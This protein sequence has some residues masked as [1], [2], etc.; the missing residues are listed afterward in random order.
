[1]EQKLSYRVIN[2]AVGI[3]VISFAGYVIAYLLRQDF[4]YD[5]LRLPFATDIGS[6]F[7][8]IA[9]SDVVWIAALK[10][11]GNTVIL[12]ALGIVIASVIGLFVGIA[13]LSKNPLL[14][15]MGRIYVEIVRNVPL[16]VLMFLFAFVVFAGLP[17]IG[18]QAGIPGILYFSNRGIAVPELVVNNGLW[19]LWVI[20]LIA[21]AVGAVF[22]RR[23]LYRREMATG[24]RTYG[25]VVAGLAWL[26]VAVLS[27]ILLGGPLV[28]VGPIVD[29]SGLFPFY[30]RG[31]VTSLG[32]ISAL[33]AISVYFGAF[34]AEIVR[35]SVQAIPKQQSEAAASLG[36]SSAQSLVLVI[37]PQA[38]RIMSPALNNEYQNANKDSSLSHLITYSEI[39]FIAIQIANNRGHFIELFLGVFMV[40]VL[41]NV[42]ISLAMNLLNKMVQ[43]VS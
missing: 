7:F 1:M 30:S 28:L 26:L 17:G 12:V 32:Y 37:L 8:K 36:L 14:S 20:V 41:L 22:L 42:L 24:T 9:S 25:R 16:L 3:A 29:Q 35:G 13:R 27:H 11:V 19:I 33:L 23:F 18:E 21:A 39:V 40:F 5:F 15:G 34:I 38:L 31:S 6:G 2:V 10:G 43:V 4:S